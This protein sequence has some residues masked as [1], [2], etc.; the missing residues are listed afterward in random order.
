MIELLPRELLEDYQSGLRVHNNVAAKHE[1]TSKTKA[2]HGACRDLEGL[3]LPIAADRKPC[4]LPSVCDGTPDSCNQ[5]ATCIHSQ[6]YG[7]INTQHPE[8]Q[9]VF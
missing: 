5:S 9:I 7:G 2:R 8:Q 3:S 1:M 6:E 4:L